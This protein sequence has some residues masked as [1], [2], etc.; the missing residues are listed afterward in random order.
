MTML[1]RTIEMRPVDPQT[2]APVGPLAQP[3]YYPDFHTLDQQSYWDAKTRAVVIDR[4]D[5]VPPIRFFNGQQARTLTAI[6]DRILPQDDRDEAHRIPIVPQIDRRLFEDIGDGYRYEG[7]PPDPEAFTL[8]IEAIEQ[9]AQ[10]M[11]GRDFASLGPPDQEHILR[12]LHDG[13]PGAAHDIWLRLPVE[14]FWT[15]L[16]TD[17]VSAYYA[18]PYAWDEIGFGGPAYP[19]AYMRLENGEPEPW[20]SEEQRY[21]WNPPRWSVSGAF[22]PVGGKE[23]QPA[24]P[25]Q[26][27]MH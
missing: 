2:G 3:G 27:G 24:S 19:R 15:L 22:E 8:G 6:C 12:S 18:H 26:G 21:A 14:R 23:E 10:A 7:M 25:S 5:N 11:H 17:C 4:V 1:P 16:V 9:I 13:T 20:E